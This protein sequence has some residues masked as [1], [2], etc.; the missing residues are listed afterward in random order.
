MLIIFNNLDMQDFAY[1]D[2]FL[3][4]MRIKH[5]IF[6]VQADSKS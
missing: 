3:I 5:K 4:L 6:I 1:D 2:W